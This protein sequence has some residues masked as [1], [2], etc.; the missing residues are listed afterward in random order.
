[1]NKVRD[2][3]T[4]A[5][6][7]PQFLVRTRCEIATTSPN[8][9]DLA[10]WRRLPPPSGP[11]PPSSLWCGPSPWGPPEAIIGIKM[12]PWKFVP[13]QVHLS[14][15]RV[16]PADAGPEPSWPPSSAPLL[17]IESVSATATVTQPEAEEFRHRHDAR[18]LLDDASGG[19]GGRRRGARRGGRGGGAVGHPDAARRSPHGGRGGVG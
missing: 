15:N 11:K 6:M 9:A 13:V 8:P 18:D 7:P 14:Q 4:P 16:R 1:M 3:L 19:G 2:R 17:L 5:T 12:Q 10:R